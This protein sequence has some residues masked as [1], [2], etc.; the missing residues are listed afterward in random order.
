VLN[1][2]FLPGK[3]Q[4]PDLKRSGKGS[5]K[6]IAS[7]KVVT[8]RPCSLPCQRGVKDIEKQRKVEADIFEKTLIALIVIWAMGFLTFHFFRLLIGRRNF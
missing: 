4:F 5:G 1:S 6:K 8:T 2:I 3:D 7:R